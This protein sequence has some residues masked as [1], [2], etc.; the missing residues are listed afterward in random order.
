[1]KMFWNLLKNLPNRLKIFLSKIIPLA[2]PK[3]SFDFYKNFCYN[4][5]RNCEE[6]EMKNMGELFNRITEADQLAM[7]RYIENYGY[8]NEYSNYSRDHASP[9]EYRLRFWERA[10]NEYLANMFGDNL[11]LERE[12]EFETP[13]EDLVAKFRCDYHG[14]S[15]YFWSDLYALFWDNHN[16]YEFCY[17]RHYHNNWSGST[18]SYLSCVDTLMRNKWELPETILPMPEGKKYKICPGTKI[19]R[20]LGHLAKAYG[21]RDWE[22]VREAHSKAV[23]AKYTK[24]TLCLSIHPFDYITMS[25]NC[26]TWDSCMNWIN[27]GGYRAGTVEMMNS[28][29]VVVA[30]LKHPTHRL[31]DCWN[32][33]TWRELFIVHPDIIA[34]IK[35]YPYP[36]APLEKQILNWIKEL[37]ETNTNMSYKDEL[38]YLD[39]DESEYLDKHKIRVRFYTDTMYNDCGRAEQW[40]Y[41]GTA[42]PDG[43]QIGVNYSGIRSCMMCGSETEYFEDDDEVFC[44]ECDNTPKYYCEECGESMDPGDYYE[45]QGEIYCYHC[46]HELFTEAYDADEYVPIDECTPLYIKLPN[47][48][49]SC[50]DAFVYNVDAFQTITDTTLQYT[51]DGEAYLPY[52]EA[53]NEILNFCGITLFQRMEYDNWDLP[54]EERK[55]KVDELTKIFWETGEYVR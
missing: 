23:T 55:K 41:L 19:T 36:N 40:M 5:Y 8:N 48:A 32:S 42:V 7:C 22:K 54:V 21:L 44:Q 45:Y 43:G 33:K 38:V 4:D 9:L 12:V 16:M 14:N 10:K 50:K 15:N 28:P 46:F 1:M 37:M 17:D 13:V 25:D 47:G 35:P 51:E 6:K 39:G 34:N 11:I 26:E 30:Y 24:G 52:N 2:S 27:G 49:M 18:Y 29:C 3:G 53:S 31:D 20:V